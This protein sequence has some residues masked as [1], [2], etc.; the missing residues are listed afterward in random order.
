MLGV[1][2][3]DVVRLGEGLRVAATTGDVASWRRVAHSLAGAAGAV[4]AVAL[5]D[6]CR[7]AMTGAD[8]GPAEMPAKMA[9]IDVLCQQALDD[10]ALFIGR[11]GSGG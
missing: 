8:I 5:E 2:V 6:A 4:G 1:F 7:E 3:A 11:S 9:G 10:T